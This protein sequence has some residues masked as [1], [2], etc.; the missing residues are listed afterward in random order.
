M[1]KSTV[2]VT[3]EGVLACFRECGRELRDV[4][5]NDHGRS[6][7]KGNMDT[8]QHIGTGDTELDG[9][10]HRHIDDRRDEAVT[11]R[12]HGDSKRAVTVILDAEIILCKLLG[13]VQ[14]RGID[15]L[16]IARRRQVVCQCLEPEN[17]AHDE[18]QQ[19]RNPDPASLERIF[20]NSK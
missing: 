17:A 19:E 15:S 3:Q 11:C 16:D 10:I 4:A 20:T 8:M 5:R 12:D 1:T 14:T 13:E 6:V 2:F 9:R 7:R 18:R